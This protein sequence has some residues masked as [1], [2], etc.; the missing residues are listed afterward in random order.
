MSFNNYPHKF[1]NNKIIFS[2][3]M[4]GLATFLLT[5]CSPTKNS[6]YFKT[7][8]RDTSIANTL[9]RVPETR[10]RKND[11][12]S[13]NISS[14]N[15]AE[16]AVFNAAAGIGGANA[17]SGGTAAG[18][19]VDAAGNIQVHRLGIIHAEGMTRRELKNKLEQDITPYL[20]D[21]VVTIRFLNH[22]VTLL[23]EV[24]APQVITM[25][26]EQL[27]LLEVLGSSGDITPLAKRDNILIIRENENSKQF[28]RINLEDH[29]IFTSEWYYLQPGDV[30]YVEPS[31]KRVKDEKRVRQQQ[32]ISFA[33]SG[34][35]LAI[36]ILDRI[37]R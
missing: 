30:V 21:P 7:L 23:G 19:T 13:I 8:P 3:L 10:I 22:R 27:S 14:L 29:S 2:L 12:L 25:P 15:P 24:A 32:T 35:S 4:V 11:Q 16:D 26:E 9:N 33:L 5:S 36:I 34:I 17:L 1:S 31:D 20:K 28:K 18:Y 6:Y 37:L